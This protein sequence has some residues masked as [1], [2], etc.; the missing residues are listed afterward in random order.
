VSWVRDGDHGTQKR[1]PLRFPR[2]IPWS[3]MYINPLATSLSYDGHVIVRS[4][5]KGGE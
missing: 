4:E 1:T 3:C 5:T 2:I